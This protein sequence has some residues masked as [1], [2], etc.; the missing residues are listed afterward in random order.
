VNQPR[1]YI[2]TSRGRQLGRNIRL[3]CKT[4]HIAVEMKPKKNSY[5]NRFET[6]SFQLFGQFKTVGGQKLGSGDSRVRVGRRLG[7]LLDDFLPPCNT[8]VDGG[9]RHH[10]DKV[11]QPCQARNGAGQCCLPKYPPA[12]DVLGNVGPRR[13]RRP[14]IHSIHHPLYCTSPFDNALIR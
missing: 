1:H 5:R 12:A 14:Y 13:H 11:W 3:R 2:R 8:R 9:E 10:F 6:V 7:S 4:V